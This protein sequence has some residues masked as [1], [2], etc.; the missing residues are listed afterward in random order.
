MNWP[1]IILA[2]ASP[3]RSE[4]LNQLG[5]KFQVVASNVPELHH[6]QLTALEVCQIN[7]YRK[8]RSVAKKRPD[9][10][11][12]AADTL[13]YLNNR[14]FGKPTSLEEAFQMLKALQGQ[15]HQVV[16]ALCLMHLR[17]H[18][19]K[20]C[21]ETTAVTFRAL[22][23]AKIRHYL[24]K[25]DPLDKA[26]AYAIQEKGDLIVEG[27]SGSYTNVVGLPVERLQAELTEWMNGTKPEAH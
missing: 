22:D 18:R 21:A 13:V 1:S 9:A 27:I 26:G 23:A 17:E 20:L 6:D 10:L 25:I 14:L 24:N 15:T 7:A 12:L 4:L 19:Q 16:T 2:S 5:V 3:R 11:V 8:A